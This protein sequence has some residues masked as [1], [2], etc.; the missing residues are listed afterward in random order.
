MTATPVYNIVN[1]QLNIDNYNIVYQNHNSSFD[2][3]LKTLDYNFCDTEI[4]NIGLNTNLWISNDPIDFSQKSIH[5]SNDAH[6]NSILFFHSVP[7]N[8]FKKE[9]ILILKQHIQKKYKV[10]CSPNLASYWLPSDSKWQTID[11][12]IPNLISQTT[13][14]DYNLV[15]LNFNNNDTINSLCSDIQKNIPKTLM[16]NSMPNSIDELYSVLQ[17]SHMC[18]DFENIINS[19]FASVCECFIISP[20][21]NPHLKYYAKIDHM[22]N[23]QNIIQSSLN[24]IDTNKILEQKQLILDR[25][26]FDIFAQRVSVL[27]NSIIKEKFIL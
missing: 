17:N 20:Y 15:I 14:K 8:Q 13:N 3:I 22:D 12:G 16:L 7:P 9:D 5:S 1:S 11:Y 18:L 2:L 4:S 6:V 21:S 24:N 10:L 26:P 27:F 19:L 25:F 23:L